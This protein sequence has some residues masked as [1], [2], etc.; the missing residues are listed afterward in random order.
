MHQNTENSKLKFPLT[1]Y[2]KLSKSWNIGSFNLLF[3]DAY[4]HADIVGII[5]SPWLPEMYI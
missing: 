3:A 5:Y 2:D 4:I 1:T